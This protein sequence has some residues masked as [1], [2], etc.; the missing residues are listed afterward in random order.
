MRLRC[1]CFDLGVAEETRRS[2]ES[3]RRQIEKVA[4]H[5]PD[6][7]GDPDTTPGILLW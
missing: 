3:M 1:A 4:P 6:S 5:T 2:E 7:R